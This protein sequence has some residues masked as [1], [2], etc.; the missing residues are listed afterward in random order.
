[1]DY[2]VWQ[3][4]W[5]RGEQLERQLSYWRERLSG[6][7]ALELPLDRPRP[8]VLGNCGGVQPVKLNAD[9]TARLRELSQRAGVTLFMTLLGAFHVVLS[10]RTGQVDVAVVKPVANRSRPEL[11][12]LIGFFVNTLV[13]RT[14]LS[15][16]PSFREVLSGC[17]R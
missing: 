10:R 6:L 4:K 15:G 16:R 2:A 13:L 9:L 11:E 1:V 5:L 14:D 8:A 7:A 17:G 3:R 12:G